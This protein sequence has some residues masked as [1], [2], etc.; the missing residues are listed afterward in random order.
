LRE[1]KLNL[2]LTVQLYSSSAFGDIPRQVEAKGD[3][4]P[5]FVAAIVHHLQRER[6]HP[7]EAL[8]PKSMG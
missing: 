2:E 1:G 8:H 6:A 4:Q 5:T 7:R 3:E